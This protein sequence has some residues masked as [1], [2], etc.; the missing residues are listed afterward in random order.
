MAF[1]E[2]KVVATQRQL[3]ADLQLLYEAVAIQSLLLEELLGPLLGT[4]DDTVAELVAGNISQL[5]DISTAV[6]QRIASSAAATV[7]QSGDVLTAIYADINQS[8]SATTQVQI[9]N[10]QDF[11]SVASDGILETESLATDILLD[12]N[13]AAFEAIEA[14]T[15]Q[16]DFIFDDLSTRLTERFEADQALLSTSIADFTLQSKNFLEVEFR[17]LDKLSDDIGERIMRSI[18]ATD[19]V[20]LESLGLIQARID[21]FIR[22]L[23]VVGD[24]LINALISESD[25]TQVLIRSAL[26]K[27]DLLGDTS[28]SGLGGGIVSGVLKLLASVTG[29]L[30]GNFSLPS[31]VKIPTKSSP[32][33][34]S[35]ESLKALQEQNF[36]DNAKHPVL[37]AIQAV[38]I[39]FANV[40]QLSSAVGEPFVQAVRYDTWSNNP[41]RIPEIQDTIAGLIRGIIEPAEVDVIFKAHGFSQGW[42]EFYR[43]LARIFL[44]LGEMMVM[45]R[46]ELYEGKDFDADLAKQ[47]FTEADQARVREVFT[48]AIRTKFRQDEDFPEEFAKRVKLQGVSDE[49]ARDYW[50]AHWALPGVAQGFEMFHRKIINLDELKSLMRALDIM[51]FWVDKLIAMSFRPIGRVDIRRIHKMGF[52]T[53]EELP[54]RYEAYGNSPEN[55]QLMANWTIAYN[56]P[57]DDAIPEELIGLSRSNVIRM[58]K[59]G[60]LTPKEAEQFLLDL[61]L[62]A[63]SAKAHVEIVL[64]ESMIDQ[65][66]DDIKDT[67]QLYS[68]GAISFEKAQTDLANLGLSADE[69]REATEDL[70]KVQAKND[71]IPSQADLFKMFGF[72]IIDDETTFATLL[73]LGFSDFWARN[74]M[75]LHAQGTN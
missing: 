70:L 37:G 18:N 74:L 55:A 49:T 38:G 48:P 63:T 6:L 59:L 5:E 19:A 73:R 67:R 43:G 57:A 26:G 13:D 31:E 35:I 20:A 22:D 24:T 12:L 14:N 46:R 50:A 66:E 29:D 21:A 34:E 32:V 4:I 11:Y 3:E 56:S 64:T 65:R 40:L 16:A 1:D 17:S 72:G 69:L 42:S 58:M 39:M 51:P 7:T 9:D 15:E 75:L 8:V 41:F 25:E 2:G 71:K 62:G 36:I 10:I 54:A 44:P 33:A 28:E 45:Q 60:M 53:D 61:G 30:A 47:G 27:L 68:A 23:D 52:I